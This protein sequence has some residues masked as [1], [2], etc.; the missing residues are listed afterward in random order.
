VILMLMAI[1]LDLYIGDSA[2]RDDCGGG[3]SVALKLYEIRDCIIHEFC[4]TTL[5]QLEGI[6]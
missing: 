4:S 6:K 3:W 5:L 2:D 1:G